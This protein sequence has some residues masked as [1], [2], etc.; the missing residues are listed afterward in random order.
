MAH[1]QSDPHTALS[2]DLLGVLDDLS[3]L[4][5]GHRPAHA[6]GVLLTGLFRR[7]LI[8][9]ALTRA[10]H[11]A[12]ESTPVTVR[13]SNGTGVP[14]I[15]DNDPNVSGP[16]GIAIRFH[17]A[18]HVHTDII[19]HSTDGFPARTAEEFLEFLRAA[20]DSR[21]DAPK[22][23]PIE[24][25]LGSHPAALKFV[26]TPKPIPASFATENYFSVNAMQFTNAAGAG[27]FGRY[28]ILPEGGARHL[29]AAAAAARSPNFLIEK[30][31]ARVAAG[32][33]R[34]RIV[35]QLAVPGDPVDDATASWPEER[36]QLD[37]GEIE[38]TAMADPTASRIIFDPI[39]RVDGIDP[40]GDPL[41]EP[42]ASLYLMSGRR[43]R[44]ATPLVTE[45]RR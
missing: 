31:A 10:P 34:L 41:L 17:L 38:L 33:V 32:P 30:I 12:R 22:P 27:R 8:A 36:E 19:G 6:K 15:P 40:S 24:K 25:F 28:R 9:R 23:T 29:D 39:P 3:G 20:R 42:R 21:P 4:H 43:R 44:A 18:D 14:T 7:S 26:T 45:P 1:P 11:I 35:V 16:R 5:P 2:K 37:F 13:F